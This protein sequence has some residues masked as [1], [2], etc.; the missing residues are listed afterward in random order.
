MLPLGAALCVWLA[1]RKAP[2][3]ASSGLGVVCLPS[4]AAS[5]AAIFAPTMVEIEGMGMTD[6]RLRLH[7][8]ST[9]TERL[10]RH[11]WIHE[12]PPHL[13]GLKFH[14]LMRLDSQVLAH[15]AL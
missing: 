6:T 2:R 1:R 3:L 9:V 10:S 7:L 13:R 4:A 15:E 11:P 8:R 14:H 12:A 5:L